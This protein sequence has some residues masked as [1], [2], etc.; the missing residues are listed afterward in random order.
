[1]SKLAIS[2]LDPVRSNARRV[3]VVGATRRTAIQ[4]HARARHALVPRR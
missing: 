1:M 2:T 4:S 3:V